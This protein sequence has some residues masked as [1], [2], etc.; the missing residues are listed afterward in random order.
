MSK[1]PIAIYTAVC[2]ADEK[3]FGQFLS[4]MTRLNLDFFIHFDKCSDET[5]KKFMQHKYFSGYTERTEG[6]YKET[7]KQGILDL[8]S[9]K[10]YQWAMCLDFDETLEKAAP[11]KLKIVLESK[12]SII[13]VPYIN[14]W[15]DK[16][17]CRI[18]G[19][20]GTA[21]REKFYN[22]KIKWKFNFPY[23][24]RPRPVTSG[25]SMKKVHIYFIHHGLMNSRLCNFHK[26]RWDKIYTHSAGM[27]PYNMWNDA[28]NNKPEIRR[29][30]EFIV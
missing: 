26:E 19:W 12:E 29:I 17:H 20:F 8:L 2:D 30:T 22:L 24:G 10:N 27:N 13:Q 21:T 18:D 9:S 23:V 15:E 11:Q 1:I 14:L 5:K 28:V 25:F 3:Y 6:V 16:K 7:D 4:E